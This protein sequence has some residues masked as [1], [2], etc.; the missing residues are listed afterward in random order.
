MPEQKTRKRSLHYK[1][2]PIDL[3]FKNRNVLLVEDSIVRGNTS[4]KIIEIA[5]EAGAKK[6][7]FASAAPPVISQDPYGIDLPTTQELIAGSHSVEEIRKHIKADGLFY[8]TIEDLHKAVQY[9][10][11]KIKKF[12]DGCFTKKY[13]TPE[14]TPALLKELGQSRNETRS[15]SNTESDEDDAKMMTLV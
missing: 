12:S 4:K 5:R 14:V 3:E 9:G 7:Y 10:N 13:P 15:A 1:F 6:V 2:H 11:K 8:G